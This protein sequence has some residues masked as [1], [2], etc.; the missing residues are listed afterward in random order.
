MKNKKG[1]TLVELMSVI[2]VLGIIIAIAIPVY[3]A[4]VKRINEKNYENQVSLIETAGAKYAE[5]TRYENFFVDDLVKDGYLNADKDGN[6]INPLNGEIMNC[7]I[8]R[9]KKENDNYYA[10]YVKDKDYRDENGCMTNIPN[11]L[12]NTFKIIAKTEDE[13]EIDWSNTVWVNKNVKLYAQIDDGYTIND[14][15]WYKGYEQQPIEEAT[16]KKEYIVST[17][18]ETSIQQMYKTIVTVTKEGQQGEEEF[19]ASIVIS[20][21]KINPFFF[22]D[23]GININ[24]KWEQFKNYNVKAQDSQS[25]LY[26]FLNNR[27]NSDCPSTK[28]KYSKKDYIKIEENGQ[29]SICIIDNAGNTAKKILDVKKVDYTKPE[30]TS[31]GDSTDWTRTSKTIYYGCTDTQSECDKSYSGGSKTFSTTTKTS[32]IASYTIKDNAGNTTTCK[33]RE[34]NVYVDVTPPECTDSGDSTTWIKTDRTISYGCKDNHSG[35]DTSYSGGNQTFTTNTKTSTIAAYTIKDKVGNPK[36]CPARSANVYIEKSIT[37]P[38]LS[39]SSSGYASVKGVYDT[40]NAISGIKSTNCYLTNNLGT[41]SSSG[42]LNSDGSCT[43]AVTAT[44]ANTSYYFKKCITSNGNNTACSAVST[45]ENVGYCTSGNYNTS[46]SYAPTGNWS[47]CSNVCGGNQ[48]RNAIRTD[49]YISK[50]NSLGCGS[51]QTPVA[52]YYS[53]GCGGSKYS[54]SSACN[55]SCPTACGKSASTQSGTRTDYYVSTLD[56]VTSCGSVPNVACSISCP[57]TASCCVN[58]LGSS[59]KTV[60]NSGVMCNDGTKGWAINPTSVDIKKNVN[61]K[62][63][64]TIKYKFSSTRTSDSVQPRCYLDFTSGYTTGAIFSFSGD[65]VYTNKTGTVTLSS[66]NSTLAKST[67]D[68]VLR[69]TGTAETTTYC[70]GQKVTC[71]L[72]TLEACP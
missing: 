7:Y 53:Q 43:F 6:V 68:F 45:K 65:K 10:S 17:N 18:D 47:G 69:V 5:D 24:D 9:I 38:T 2:V 25:S 12:N 27:K 33:S 32:T 1:F 8:V 55:A 60:E 52:N 42:T 57:A 34:A 72:K 40:G 36:T 23:D 35:C 70:M 61:L 31:S 49:T 48:Y 4:V 58:L 66:W 20:I 14:I 67:G 37:A 3:N 22:H 16:G 30:C 56:G 51:S 50:Y 13:K 44:S 46:S 41:V 62:N 26:G 21:D 64:K 71:T 15:K 39:S 11:T 54:S 29:Y 19:A 28:N 63:Y 59:N